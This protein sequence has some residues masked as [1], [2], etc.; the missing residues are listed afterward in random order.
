MNECYNTTMKETITRS[1]T[2]LLVILIG[3]GALLN[4]TN[5][6]N[7]WDYLG[8]W[9]SMILVI[10]GILI[11]INHTRQYITA[12]AFVI[13]GV[14]LQLNA[15][16]IITVDIWNVF[17]PIIIIAVGLSILINQKATHPKNIHT[18]DLDSLS[19]FFSGNETI[20]TSKDYKGGK[21]TAIFGAVTID[22]RDAIIKNEATIE[23]FTLCGG[24]ELKVPREWRVKHSVLPVLGGVENKAHSND[25]KA[26]TLYITGTA[27]LGG[28]EVKT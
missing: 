19:A 8:N 27:A 9:W 23:V 4:A 10:V 13:A 14:I 17:W 11:F 5:V 21:I 6:F 18:Q 24:V 1:I 7:F 15:L 20:N 28:V 12:L 22:L 2:G 26:P 25:D 16:A 3:L